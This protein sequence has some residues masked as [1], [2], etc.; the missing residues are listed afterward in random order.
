VSRAH[1]W[2]WLLLTSAI[3]DGERRRSRLRQ[4]LRGDGR[5]SARSGSPA[6]R[7]PIARL[8]VASVLFLR[9]CRCGGRRRCWRHRL[10]RHPR[11]RRVRLRHSLLGFLLFSASCVTIAHEIAPLGKWRGWA[12]LPPFNWRRVRARVE[13][14]YGGTVPSVKSARTKFGWPPHGLGCR[15]RG[16]C[17]LRP[18]RDT[19]LTRPLLPSGHPVSLLE[20]YFNLPRQT[21]RMDRRSGGDTF[22]HHFC[23][24]CAICRCP[25]DGGKCKPRSAW[26]QTERGGGQTVRAALCG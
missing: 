5:G 26:G 4:K 23:V 19:V 3:A 17:A 18:G 8:L 20:G 11:R 15:M 16:C 25:A 24:G 22:R 1:L 6:R 12:A 9:S 10:V 7:S 2:A 21:S 14:F 13:L